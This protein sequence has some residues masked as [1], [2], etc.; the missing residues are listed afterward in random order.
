MKISITFEAPEKNRKIHKSPHYTIASKIYAPSI[1]LFWIST[2]HTSLQ[3]PKKRE[4]ASNR[5]ILSR[6]LNREFCS[7]EFSTRLHPTTGL[8]G[9]IRFQCG[10]NHATNYADSAARKIPLKSQICPLIKP[11]WRV[12]PREK[13]EKTVNLPKAHH[14]FLTYLPFP[15]GMSP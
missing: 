9:F 3:Q 6:Y 8:T 4:F 2:I 15:K 12:C 13:K 7:D 10:R 5:A 1:I 14:L 11:F